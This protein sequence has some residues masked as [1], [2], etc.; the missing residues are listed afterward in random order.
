MDYHSPE[1]LELDIY[2]GECIEPERSH[3]DFIFVL[4]EEK[5]KDGCLTILLIFLLF[6]ANQPCRAEE[7]AGKLERVDID[8]VTILGC[9]NRRLV[10][11]VDRGSRLAAAPFLGKWVTVD[12]T[13]A[14]GEYQAVRF[15]SCR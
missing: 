4:W 7:F 5:M 6:C 15:R 9:G 1:G 11:R 13:T 10:I 3:R 14:G 2:L 12:L 8:T